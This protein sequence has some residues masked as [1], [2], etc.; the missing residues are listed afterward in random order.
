M[1]GLISLVFLGV[2]RFSAKGLLQCYNGLVMSLL[3]LVIEKHFP[4]FAE[5]RA[6]LRRGHPLKLENFGIPPLVG[7]A[8]RQRW[9]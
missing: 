4:N 6:S 7:P 1:K 2:L 9:Q 3:G 8:A 5:M